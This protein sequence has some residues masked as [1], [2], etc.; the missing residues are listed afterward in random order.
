[1]SHIRKKEINLLIKTVYMFLP[2]AMGPVRTRHSSHDFA[3]QSSRSVDLAGWQVKTASIEMR[4]QLTLN[5]LN[6]Q[7]YYLFYKLLS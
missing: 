2:P 4:A 3:I 5:L 6:S 7:L 1:M